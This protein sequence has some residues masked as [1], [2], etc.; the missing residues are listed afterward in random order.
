[1]YTVYNDSRIIM[2]PV[3]D[4]DRK[5][6][7]YV[8]AASHHFQGKKRHSSRFGGRKGCAGALVRAAVE[9]K[10][11][12]DEG[13]LIYH[14][15]PRGK[16]LETL[17]I[18]GDFDFLYEGRSRNSTGWKEHKCRHQW[19]HNLREQEKHQKNHSRKALHRRACCAGKDEPQR[20]YPDIN[21]PEKRQSWMPSGTSIAEVTYDGSGEIP[22][23]VNKFEAFVSVRKT[24]LMSGRELAGATLQ[25]LD[26]NGKVIDEW[27][28]TT[29]AHEITGLKTC[30][31]YTLH[32][33]AAPDGYLIAADTTFTLNEDGSINTGKTTGTVDSEG[34]LLVE[35][36]H[37]EKDA[38]KGTKGPHRGAETG[39]DANIALWVI[40]AA[41]AAAGAAG[42]IAAGKRKKG[43]KS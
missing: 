14:W 38:K 32:E 15:K 35:D 13:C 3:L 1:M 39:D 9:E 11:Y 26:N 17:L 25:V 27:T 20:A 4:H 5:A 12:D 10:Y 36:A 28:S 19:E 42:I 31:T 43:R 23:F 8:F 21:Y 37:S 29:K 6:G 22:Q 7:T 34:V 18:L 30:V 16:Q 33:K 40:L 41:A 2:G 24:D